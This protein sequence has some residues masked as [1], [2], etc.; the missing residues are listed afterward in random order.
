[1]PPFAI[2]VLLFTTDAHLTGEGVDTR[3]QV[4]NRGVAIGLSQCQQRLICQNL[5]EAEA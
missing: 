5:A 1:M 3:E 4:T 2:A